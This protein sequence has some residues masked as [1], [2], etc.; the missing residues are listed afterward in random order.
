MTSLENLNLSHNQLTKLPKDI[1]KLKS[2]KV[3]D[4][5]WNH[6]MYNLDFLPIDIKVNSTWN[7]Q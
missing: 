4:I 2:L 5:S 7:R 1:I 3:L 6:I